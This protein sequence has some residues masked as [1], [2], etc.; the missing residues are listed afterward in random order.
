MKSWTETVFGAVV[1]L[2]LLACKQSPPPKKAPELTVSAQDL[3]SAY[4]ANEAAADQKYKGK[5]LEVSGAI[6]A[7]ESDFSD[8]PVIR[9]YTGDLMGASARGLSKAEAAKLAKDQRII[10]ICTGDGELVGSPQLK[11]CRLP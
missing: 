4:N 7:I 9:L 10:I 6:T 1:V 8:N 5:V 3:R 11:D 2:A